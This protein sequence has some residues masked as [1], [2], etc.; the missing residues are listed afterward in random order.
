MRIADKELTPA[1]VG[2]LAAALDACRGYSDDTTVGVL[3]E[4]LVGER[5][6]ND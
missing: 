4:V 3:E 2:I 5:I 6:G 1:E